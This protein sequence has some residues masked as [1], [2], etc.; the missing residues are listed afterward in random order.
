[1]ILR[2][3]S[4]E[5]M[6]DDILQ[7]NKKILMFGAGVIGQITVPEILKKY[8]LIQYLDS[9]IDNNSEKWKYP[10]VL[11]NREY[12]IKS[13]A[14][15]T[16]CD[17]N[18]TILINISR[19]FEVKAQLENMK[20]TENMTVYIMPMMC[21]HNMCSKISEGNIV[22]SEKPLIPKKIHYMWL[23]GSP[24]PFKLQKCIDTWKS[25]C[26]DYEIIEWNEKNY[27]IGRHPYMEQAYKAGAYGFVPDYAR[28]D[29]LYYYGGFYL[30]T[31]VEL[32]KSLDELR[33][34]EAFCGVEK[35]QV[36]NFGG[37]SG[38]VRKHP[39]IKKFLDKRNQI[40]FLD[41]KKNQNKNTCGFYDTRVILNEGYKIDGT[42]Q[43]VNG[44]NIYAYDYFH[45]YD[46]MSGLLN[47]TEHTYSVH[48]FN[49]GWLDENMKKQNMLTKE[50]YFKLYKDCLGKQEGKNVII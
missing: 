22:Q 14:Y 37:C 33:S 49:G 23:G 17:K 6:A 43:C 19:F 25:H 21:I 10:I 47:I 40:Y 38:A 28:L 1:M 8:D 30:D 29:I 4:F 39:M 27:D 9:Y 13:P 34:Q 32:L 45:P 7:N 3:C 11:D 31:D 2:C 48:H 26:P 46:Y 12:K 20:C 15:L 18:T 50:R 35:W 41:D 24:I 44:M 36:L 42:S 5:E 16:E